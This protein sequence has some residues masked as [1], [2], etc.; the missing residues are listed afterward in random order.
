MEE[1][2][3]IKKHIEQY[4]QLTEEEEQFFFSLLRIVKV[5]KKQHLI[6]PGPVCRYRNFINQGTMRAYFVD[7]KGQDHTIAF[8]IEDWWIS[9]FN[10]FI[11][12]E[13]ATL[14]VEA[15]E[16]ATLVQ[17]DYQSEQLLL[18]TVPKFERVFRI[19]GQRGYVFLQRRMLSSLSLSAE[20]RYE[21]FF[22]KYPTIVQR[23][24]QYTL[25]SYLGFTTEFLSKIRNKRAKKSSS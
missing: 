24:P 25:A 8:G 17:I 2:Q 9:D 18:E 1:F 19:I 3:A 15:L 13:P 16:D 23:V 20:E 6:E 10:S 11:F 5:K 22:Q 14:Y 12:Q 21:Q 7:A 4:V